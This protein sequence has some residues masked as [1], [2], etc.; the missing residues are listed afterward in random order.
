M[1]PFQVTEKILVLIHV[2]L[3]FSAITLFHSVRPCATHSSWQV[4]QER[5]SGP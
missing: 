2:D 5:V 1:R 4:V 3:P